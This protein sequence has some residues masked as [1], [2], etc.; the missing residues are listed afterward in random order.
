MDNLPICSF[1]MKTDIMPNDQNIVKLNS[2]SI[3]ACPSCYEDV[4]FV[5]ERLRGNLIPNNIKKFEQIFKRF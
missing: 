3:I 4:V 2:L 5:V 1:C